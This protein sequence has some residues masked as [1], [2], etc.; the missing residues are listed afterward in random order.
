MSNLPEPTQI[1]ERLGAAKILPVL[2]CATAQ[3]GYDLALRLLRCGLTALELTAT[4]PDWQDLLADL[5]REAPG[6]LIGVGTIVNENT[7]KQALDSGADFLVSPY[8]SESVRSVAGAAGSLFIEGGFTPG[9]LAAAAGKGVAK[10]FPAHV[11]GPS[12][13]KSM[14]AILPGSRIIPTGGIP[15]A[16]VSRWLAAGAFAVGVG[17]DLYSGDDADITIPALLAEIGMDVR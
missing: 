1:V 3:E 15:V 16:D 5:R 4:T 17:R 7:A 2:R 13:L 10:L 9:E 11:G 12:Y 14:L 6:A 8:P